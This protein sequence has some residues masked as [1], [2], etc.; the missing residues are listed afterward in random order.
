MAAETAVALPAVCYPG[1]AG[2]AGNLERLA[3]N[4]LSASPRRGHSTETTRWWL[5][6]G[7]AAQIQRVNK[8][9]RYRLGSGHFLL[10][11]QVMLVP[12]R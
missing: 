5:C 7:Y 11:Q 1:D 6:S 12:E 9:A 4:V 10:N 8:K 2:T 3:P